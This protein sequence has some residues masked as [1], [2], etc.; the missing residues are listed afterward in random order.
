MV[1]LQQYQLKRAFR[2]SL[3][4]LPVLAIC[5]VLVVAPLLRWFDHATS[6][7][8]FNFTPDGARTILG[9]FS[10]S[11]LTFVVF[12][13][14]SLLIVVQ[15]ASAQLTPRVIALVF[16][17]R[18]LKWVLSIFT[19]AYTYTIAASGRIEDTTP[20]LPVAFAIICNLVCIVIF[21]WFVQWLGGS[22][23]PIAVLQ[24]VAEEGRL[25]GGGIRPPSAM[26]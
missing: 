25:S 26:R 18:H 23:R 7:S 10:S 20:Q 22:L 15:L 3:W 9:A 1:W 2:W 5:L 11:M 24:T 17:D 12:V 8:W 21:F 14:S 19:F 13:V 16:A 4:L 6:W